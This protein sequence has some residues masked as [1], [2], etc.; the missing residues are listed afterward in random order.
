MKPASLFPSKTQQ[1]F[2]EAII[3]LAVIGTTL[4]MRTREFSDDQLNYIVIAEKIISGNPAER[5][6]VPYKTF[7]FLLAFCKSWLGDYISALRLIYVVVAYAY[8]KAMSWGL[9]YFLEHKRWTCLVVSIVSLVPQY[10]L[11]MTYWGFAGSYFILARI[12]A[13]PVIPVAFR[14]FFETKS[15]W[16]RFGALMLTAISGILSQEILLL[17][18]AFWFYLCVELLIFDSCRKMTLQMRVTVSGLLGSALAVW[19]IICAPAWF[20]PDP[21][22][23]LNGV[24]SKLAGA[25]GSSEASWQFLQNADFH[26][27]AAYSACWW[28]LFPP[29]LS[30]LVFGF[31]NM[32]PLLVAAIPG[33]VFL[34]RHRR[35]LFLSMALI[36]G[37]VIVVA[38]AYPFFRWLCWKVCGWPPDIWE[39]VR[40]IKFLYFP[41]YVSIGMGVLI[42]WREKRRMAAAGLLLLAAASPLQI[43]RALPYSL[44]EELSEYAFNWISGSD[45]Q[46]YV[47]KAFK[48]VDYRAQHDI[49]RIKEIL[50]AH[51]DQVSGVVSDLY[52]LKATD[53]DIYVT[54]ND[55][56]NG[57]MRAFGRKYQ[58]LPLWHAGYKEISRFMDECGG[59]LSAKS[60]NVCGCES[61]KAMAIMRK[62]DSRFI[63]LPCVYP[64]KSDLHILYQGERF[65]LYEI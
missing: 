15:P 65:S 11:G 34:R 12:L 29:A 25:Y 27:E 49:R 31:F 54:Y 13:M 7:S 44:R 63:V 28:T 50:N 17:W 10:T 62:F 20:G 21:F 58:K 38:Y 8:L 40:A 32:F 24:Y 53:R 19:V 3:W 2:Y 6:W 33:L 1:F 45:K 56:R 43:I 14:L 55:K 37:A 9:E 18:V 30:D 22:V 23:E 42:F 39:E 52:D 57:T 61:S 36:S 59:D 35:S 16:N 48:V 5:I 41:I 51:Q 60:E 26:W 47:L 4:L 64:E 46:R